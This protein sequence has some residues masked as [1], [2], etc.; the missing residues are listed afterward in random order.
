MMV[1]ARLLSRLALDDSDVVELPLFRMFSEVLIEEYAK[2]LFQD[3]ID[4]LERVDVGNLRRLCDENVANWRSLYG[5]RRELITRGDAYYARV[6]E[7]L[8]RF[9]VLPAPVQSSADLHTA[10]I[11]A[12]QALPLLR[13]LLEGIGRLL[14]GESAAH[15][16]CA[17][18]K[19][20]Y[21]SLEKIAFETSTRK[22]S[23]LCVLDIARGAIE[24]SST[25]VMFNAV[26]LLEACTVGARVQG[27]NPH[28]HVVNSLPA[29]RVVRL[30]NRFEQC[31][32]SGWADIL[33]NITF[34]DDP[35]QHVTEIQIQHS[36]LVLLRGPWGGHKGYAKFRVLSELCHLHDN[37]RV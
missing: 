18:L 1:F 22:W 6:V 23:A 10:Y 30:K 17:P 15:V 28:V 12:C 14:G 4:D 11:H 13:K 2:S 31:T 33:L 32:E 7:S 37:G 36:N 35:N 16:V 27:T 5:M 3:V 9:I 29:I 21:R 19:R 8:G 26:S 25:S 20:I 24:C 34:V